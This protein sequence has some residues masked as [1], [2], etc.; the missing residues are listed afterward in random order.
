MMVQGV[1]PLTFQLPEVLVVA[2]VAKVT[3]VTPSLPERPV[4]VK[5]VAPLRGAAAIG[6]GHGLGGHGELGRG[7]VS[8]QA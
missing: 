4:A 1:P 3:E 8:G 6:P 7:D 2:L 5:P